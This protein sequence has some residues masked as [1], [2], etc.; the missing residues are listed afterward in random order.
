M[1]KV[2][3]PLLKLLVLGSEMY[4]LTYTSDD[5]S[6]KAMAPHSNFLLPGKSHGWRSLVGCSPWGH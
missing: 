6:E 2:Y 1:Y 5:N 3:T 4:V